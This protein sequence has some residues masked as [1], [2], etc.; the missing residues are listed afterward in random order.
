MLIITVLALIM[1][2]TL[3]WL[4]LRLLREEQR[5]SDARIAALAAALDEAP[6]GGPVPVGPAATVPPVATLATAAHEP[7]PAPEPARALEPRQDYVAVESVSAGPPVVET[8]GL[9]SDAAPRETSGERRWLGAAAVV[10]AGLLGIAAVWSGAGGTGP[11]STASAAAASHEGIPL[12]LLGLGHE[13]TGKTLVIRG[14]VRNPPA[15]SIRTGTTASVFLFDEAGGFLRNGRG[16]IDVPALAGGDE[17]T[18]EVSVDADPRIRR[19]RVTF[20]GADDTVVPHVD[21]RA[22][23]AP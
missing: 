8:R 5:R 4:L 2:A 20:R 23:R 1:A 9:F 14:L 17:A 12:E 21:K 22:P 11:A 10:C 3:G 16:P 19:Y 13:Q 7:L 18:F 15:G 6:T